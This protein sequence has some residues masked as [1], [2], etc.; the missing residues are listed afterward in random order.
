VLHLSDI[1]PIL[2]SPL[3]WAVVI[4]VLGWP[5]LLAGGVA[6]LI[7]GW[8][9][10]RKTRPW[11]GSIAGMVTGLADRQVPSASLVCNFPK[12]TAT[13][14]ALLEHEQQKYS[15]YPYEKGTY[16][17]ASFGHL[18]SY[19]SSYYTYMWSLFLSEDMYTRF[20]AEGLMNPN[21]AQAY[22]QAILEPG[23]TVDAIDMVKT[24]LGKE[25]SFDALK[26]YLEE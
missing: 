20:K 7:I 21:T 11:L 12:P 5:V 1:G 3:G 13:T 23:G 26:A 8:L 16:V 18:E 2:D 24:F 4:V 6:G 9:I 25:P 14:P 15:P 17:Y 10:V 19:T 22:R